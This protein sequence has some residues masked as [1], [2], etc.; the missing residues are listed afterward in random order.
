[1]LQKEETVVGS[2]QR[3]YYVAT[4]SY[5]RKIPKNYKAS[6]EFWIQILEYFKAW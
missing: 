5:T 6:K 1:M 4:K 3:N 2:Q